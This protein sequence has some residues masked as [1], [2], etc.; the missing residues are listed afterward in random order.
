MVRADAPSWTTS[1]SS[2]LSKQSRWLGT[3]NE[4]SA[5]VRRGGSSGAKLVWS[6]GAQ[7]CEVDLD[8]QCAVCTEGD[9]LV[10]RRAG[11]ELRFR[12]SPAPGS[13]T[14][15][16]WQAALA[17]VWQG[18]TFA[19]VLRKRSTWLR[20]W[21]V[22]HAAIQQDGANRV[23]I[24]TSSA[25]RQAAAPFAQATAIR[26]KVV[27]EALQEICEDPEVANLM[28]ELLEVEDIPLDWDIASSSSLTVTMI[29]A[30]DPRSM[31]SLMMYRLSTV[32]GRSFSLSALSLR[33]SLENCLE[34]WRA[35]R[36]LMLMP[37]M[38][39]MLGWRNRDIK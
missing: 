5:A 27:G 21:N 2:P 19:G 23:D 16:D 7:Q 4:R 12:A 18:A 10:V 30:S 29:S 26:P 8:E 32:L 14:L 36:F 11:R 39:T 28:F 6:G 25:Q 34:L 22:R 20:R 38:S 35:S 1:F 3:W 9:R 24:I 15:A 13:S 17:V 37:M 31:N 33:E